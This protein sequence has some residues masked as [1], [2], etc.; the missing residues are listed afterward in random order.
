M[1]GIWTLELPAAEH[2]MNKMLEAYRG[3]TAVE[4]ARTLMRARKQNDL[5]WTEHYQ[6]LIAVASLANLPDSFVLQ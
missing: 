1:K 4:L 2:L 5:S 6:F 3:E